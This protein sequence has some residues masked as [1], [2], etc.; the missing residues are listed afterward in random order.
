MHWKSRLL[1]AV[2]HPLGSVTCFEE[3]LKGTKTIKPMS[4]KVISVSPCPCF[5]GTFLNAHIRKYIDNNGK[6][7]SVTISAF[8]KH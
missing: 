3:V 6:C 1:S 5:P 4:R 2:H 8:P 7:E